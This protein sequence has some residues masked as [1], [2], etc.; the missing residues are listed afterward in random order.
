MSPQ[1]TPHFSI[2]SPKEFLAEKK[3]HLEKLREEKEEAFEKEI[4]FLA[5]VIERIDERALVTEKHEKEMLKGIDWKYWRETDESGWKVFANLMSSFR[6][7]PQNLEEQKM[8]DESKTGTRPVKEILEEI[9]LTPA[10]V[11]TCWNFPKMIASHIN[12]EAVANASQEQEI[13]NMRWDLEESH[14]DP[15]GLAFTLRILLLQSYRG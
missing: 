5:W 3:A 11:R 2:R 1:P 4:E 9:A 8:I 12:S 10:T 13:R 15:A 6:I 14:E 7:H